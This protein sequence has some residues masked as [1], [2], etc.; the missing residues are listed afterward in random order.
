MWRLAL[1]ADC[2]VVLSLESR[3]RT[4]FDRC[5]HYAQTTATSQITMRAARA[6]SRLALSSPQIAPAGCRLPRGRASQGSRAQPAAEPKRH[7]LAGC[8]LLLPPA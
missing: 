4:R 6:D 1:R 5:A 7:G 8:T 2:T 3:R